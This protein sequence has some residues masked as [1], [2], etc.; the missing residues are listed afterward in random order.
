MS[1]RATAGSQDELVSRL[2]MYIRNM[3]ARISMARMS[4]REKEAAVAQLEKE[5]W[6]LESEVD[7]IADM[8]AANAPAQPRREEAK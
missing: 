7:K 4:I 1:T 2:R 5:K 3:D 6:E 8:V